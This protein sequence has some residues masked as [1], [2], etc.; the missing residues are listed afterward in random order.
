M[1]PDLVDLAMEYPTTTGAL[2]PLVVTAAVYLALC[3]ALRTP[4]WWRPALDETREVPD[5]R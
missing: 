2:I 4:P 5:V 1:I 3:L